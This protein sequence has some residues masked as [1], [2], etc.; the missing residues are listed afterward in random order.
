MQSSANNGF[1]IANI[2]LVLKDEK[3]QS[4][5]QQTA[6]QYYGSKTE[7]FSD[8]KDATRKFNN[9]LSNNINKN[10]SLKEAGKLPTFSIE[11]WNWLLPTFDETY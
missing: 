4:D 3:L 6:K 5:Y 10:T 8:Y 2:E 1:S 7:Y 9:W 11:P